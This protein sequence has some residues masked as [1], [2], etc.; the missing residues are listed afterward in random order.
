MGFM[1]LRQWISLL[2]QEGELRRITAEVDGDREIW[3]IARRVLE[4]KVPA[5][6]FENIKGYGDGRCK[7]LFVNGLGARSRLA[8]ALG[9]PRAAANRDLVQHV[10]KKN[11][12]TIAPVVVPTGPVKDIII[13]GEAIDQTEFPVP[14]W[15]YLEGGRYIHT[16]SGIVTRDPDTRV[17]NVGIYRGMVG[18]KDTA[19]FLLIKGGQHWGAH[20]VKW[21]A[22]KE[23]MPVACVIGWDPIMPFLAGSPVSAGVCEWDVMGGYR[24]EPAQLVRC[25]TVDLEV[26]ATAEIVVEGTI[27]DDPA[28]YEL[29][30]P[31]GEFTGYVSDLPTPRPTMKVTCITHRRDPIFRGSLEG[32]L[33]GSY[34][35]NS[36]MSSVQRAGIAWNILNGAG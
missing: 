3:A 7:K 34:S 5:L 20:F 22:R 11:R 12:E 28:T 29:E 32:T 17:A 13:R 35:E 19:P 26:P 18:R 2:E 14:R 21:A 10:M 6:L 24:G 31:F 33:P 23:P 25:E 4:R 16:F 27:G 30:G 36:V 15:H 8:L 1:D 9:F